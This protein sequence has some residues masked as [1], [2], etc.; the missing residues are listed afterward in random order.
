MVV[1][2]SWWIWGRL[3][4]G[5]GG[6][7]THGGVFFTTEGTEDTEGGWVLE[8]RNTSEIYKKSVRI[9]G[10]GW[11]GAGYAEGRGGVLLNG[12]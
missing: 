2:R 6:G 3:R 10:C 4:R 9:W 7:E 8:P 1:E 12:G 11:G 5:F